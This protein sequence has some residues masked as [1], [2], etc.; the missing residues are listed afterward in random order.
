MTPPAAVTT[1][2]CMH[3]APPSDGAAHCVF[4]TVALVQ[5]EHSDRSRPAGNDGTHTL[6]TGLHRLPAWR[7]IT[8]RLMLEQ[9]KIV[10]YLFYTQQKLYLFML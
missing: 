10:D 6:W 1:E 8:V 3:A 9:K 4:Q 7:E 2:Q 5:Q